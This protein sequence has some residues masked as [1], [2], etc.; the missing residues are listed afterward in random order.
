MQ[1]SHCPCGLK[2]ICHHEVTTSVLY[3][4]DIQ[5]SFVGHDIADKSV[6]LSISS[7]YESINTFFNLIYYLIE[8]QDEKHVLI[9]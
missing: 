7:I 9:L 5:H 1:A 4:V 6:D 2:Q 3:R 8:K